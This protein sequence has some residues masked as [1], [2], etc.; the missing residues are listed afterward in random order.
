VTCD[1]G[2]F[3]RKISALA[4]LMF[5]SWIPHFEDGSG[6]I[7]AV[8]MCVWRWHLLVLLYVGAMV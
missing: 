2:A 7:V 8:Q 6:S 3:R 1:F 4:K 5:D